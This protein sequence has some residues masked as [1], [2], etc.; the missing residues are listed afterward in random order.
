LQKWSNEHEIIHVIGVVN[1]QSHQQ[2]H[3]LFHASEVFNVL[4]VPIVLTKR[5][6]KTQQIEQ[7]FLTI[8]LFLYTHKYLLDYLRLFSD[9]FWTLG[10]Y[11]C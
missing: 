2:P 4:I 11:Q 1:P 10:A 8:A 7:V 5:K 9:S 6:S 3:F